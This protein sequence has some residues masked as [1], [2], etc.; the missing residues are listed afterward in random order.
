MPPDHGRAFAGGAT[1]TT[2]SPIVLIAMVLAIVLILVLP[3]KYVIVPLFFI[4]FLVPIGEQIVVGGVHLFVSRIVILAGLL[5]MLSTKMTSQG[6]AVLPTG[7]NSV[8][9]AFVWCTLCQACAVTLSSFSGDAFVNQVGFILDYLGGYFLI[10]FLLQDKENIYRAL[11]SLAFIAMIVSACML[12]EHVTLQNVFGFIGGQMKPE[13]RDGLV[14]CQGPFAHELMAGAFGATSLPLFLILWRHGKAK[15]IASIGVI[16]AVLITWTSNSS[17]SLLAIAA[18]IL[19]ICFFPMRKSMRKV[20]WGIVAGLIALQLV[21]KAPVWFAIA[22]IDLTGG[23]SSYQ[24][25]ALVDGFIRHFSDWWLM[26]TG[27][28]GAWG[29]DMWDTQNQFVMVGES[30][31]LLALIFFIA[32]IS[33]G[34]AALGSARKSVEG[35][36]RNEWFFW[37]LGAALFANVVAFFGVNYFDQMK[38]AWFAL[39]AMIPVTTMPLLAKAAVERLPDVVP[40]E[41]PM[42]VAYPVASRNTSLA[43]SLTKR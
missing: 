1:A 14:R 19:A 18:A 32:M 6:E 2:L 10:R 40:A 31:G 15:F 33:R 13:I 26:G 3:R 5:R 4:L 23:S 29:W 25:A 35:E 21:M 34:F 36:S 39:L 27:N 41:S 7:L 24:R 43:G 16:G 20:R 8:D 22:H 38:F 30:G 11:K 12:V 17:T 37:L 28:S 9:R 42:L